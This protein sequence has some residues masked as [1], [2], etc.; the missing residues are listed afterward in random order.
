MLS[1]VLFWWFYFFIE[2]SKCYP[3]PC[4]NAGKCYED[5]AGY[6]CTCPLAFYGERCEG[7]YHY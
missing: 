2:V 5:D 1:I 3:N 7:I 4:M 6:S